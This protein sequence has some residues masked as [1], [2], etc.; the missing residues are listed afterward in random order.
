MS[1]AEGHAPG[2]YSGNSATRTAKGVSSSHNQGIVNTMT[3]QIYSQQRQRQSGA[4]GPQ[5]TANLPQQTQQQ[6]SA[7]SGGNSN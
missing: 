4:G 2:E 5:N 1:H 7:V 3:P 6:P